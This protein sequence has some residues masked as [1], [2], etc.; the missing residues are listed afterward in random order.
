MGTFHND[1][2]DLHGVTVVVD[3]KGPTIYIGRCEIYL[4]DQHILLNESD[5]HNEMESGK[6]KEDYLNQAARVGFWKKHPRI[7]IK[8][9]D[10]ASVKKLSDLA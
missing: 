1:K 3:T 6:S 7:L 4:E 10:I 5:E 2:G 9:E 8:A